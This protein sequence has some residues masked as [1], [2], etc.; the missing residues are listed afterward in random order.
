MLTSISGLRRR[1]THAPCMRKRMLKNAYQHDLR[2][3]GGLDL[4]AMAAIFPSV[5]SSFFTQNKGGGGV[6]RA[7]PLDPPLSWVHLMHVFPFVIHSHDC[8]LCGIPLSF[9]KQNK[10]QF[11]Q[12]SLK[13]CL[14]QQRNSRHVFPLPCFSIG[15]YYPIT[16]R[17]KNK[18]EFS[19]I[20]FCKS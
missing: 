1:K 3:G 7:P 19:Y 18:L 5:I 17:M 6:P 4:L 15:V 9:Q 10:R 16:E 14:C 8:A 11:L 12:T 2:E 20:W 13:G